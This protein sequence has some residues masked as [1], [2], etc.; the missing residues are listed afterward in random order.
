MESWNFV[1]GNLDFHKDSLICE[2]LTQC[3]PGATRPWPIEAAVGSQ[4]TAVSTPGTKVCLPTIWCAGKVR[5]LP[6]SLAYSAGSTVPGSLEGT[7]VRGWMTNFC[8]WG[9]R[10]KT[11][12]ILRLPWC[13]CY[14]WP[15]DFSW[16]SVFILLQEKNVLT[17]QMYVF[18]FSV[19]YIPCYK[20]QITQV[21]SRWWAHKKSCEQRWN[22]GK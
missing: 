13:L 17:M 22:K 11:E 5:L 8:C 18:Q 3:S 4:A 15:L 19:S 7:F 1:Y 10:D 12:G 2:W 16:H 21:K 9:R 14:S 20:Y 6:G